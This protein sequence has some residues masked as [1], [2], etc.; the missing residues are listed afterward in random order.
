M[1]FQWL[2]DYQDLQER[3]IYL[4]WNLNKSKLELLR[5]IEGDLQGIKLKKE[6]RA[7]SLEEKITFM[8]TEIA[9]INQQLEELEEMISTFDGVDSQII[10]LKY[11][12]GL[13]LEDTADEIGYSASYVRKRHTEIK[14][15]LR[16]L[17]SYLA[18][19]KERVQRQ[20]ETECYENQLKKHHKNR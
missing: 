2:Q 17:D 3:L 15:T 9:I 12:D 14:K 18:K 16:F 10:K 6:S 13:T 7:S 4:K 8:Q 19:K 1:K 11:I 5:W 20:N